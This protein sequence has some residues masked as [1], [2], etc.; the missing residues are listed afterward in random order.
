MISK[1]FYE[2]V[3][4]QKEAAGEGREDQQTR[5]TNDPRPRWTGGTHDQ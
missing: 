2:Q 3:K 1:S 4:N 5:S